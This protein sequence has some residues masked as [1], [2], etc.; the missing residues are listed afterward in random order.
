MEDG[1]VTMDQVL[2]P[3]DHDPPSES[4]IERGLRAIEAYGHD[5]SKLTLLHV[6]PESEFPDVQ[7]PVGPWQ[8]DR[9]AREGNPVSEILAAADECAANLLIMATKGSEGFL[10]ILRG[11]T[12]EQVLRQAPCPVLSVPADY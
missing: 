1:Q 6:G 4:A 10:D 11:T 12:T 2:I 3:I 7:V 8:V 9:A 5:R